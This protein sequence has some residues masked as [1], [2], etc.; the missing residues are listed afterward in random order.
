MNAPAINIYVPGILTFPGDGKNWDGRAVSH[1]IAGHWPDLA[2]EKVEYL[3]GPIDRAF[4][5]KMRAEKLYRT[6]QQYALGWTINLV[7]HSNGCAVILAMLSDFPAWPDI[8]HLHLVCGACEA[9]FEKNYLNAWLRTRR[10]GRASVY[11]AEDDAA[12]RLAHSLPGRILGYGTLGLH[13]ALDVAPDVAGRVN[14]VLWPNYG[15]S[16]CWSDSEFE[17]TMRY[18]TQEAA[19]A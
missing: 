6:V 13:G 19:E 10:V 4:G 2:A 3:C 18:F 1:T 5:Q 15:H 12:L 16:D 17:Q 14:T 9:S 11:V 7:G 8:G